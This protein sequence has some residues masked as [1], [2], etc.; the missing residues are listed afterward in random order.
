MSDTVTVGYEI[1]MRNASGEWE[2]VEAQCRVVQ[3][4]TDPAF[5]TIR[6]YWE[7]ENCFDAAGNDLTDEL[8]PADVERIEELA[9]KKAEEGSH[10]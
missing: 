9:E 2:T 4:S 6:P 10:E 3:Y 7:M 8:A 5:G 1:D